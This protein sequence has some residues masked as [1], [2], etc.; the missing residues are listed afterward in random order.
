MSKLQGIPD[1]M[2][3]I[4]FFS[5]YPMVP[6]P[7]VPQYIKVNLGITKILSYCHINR[8]ALYWLFLSVSE[9]CQSLN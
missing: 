7:M 3:Q 1:N 5:Y 2:C 9:V 4:I 6:P 8:E